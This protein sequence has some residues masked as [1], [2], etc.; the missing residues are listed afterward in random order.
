MVFPARSAK[1]QLNS[2]RGTM[3]SVRS[4]RRSYKQDKWSNELAVGK[5]PAGKN[6]STE[7]EDIVGIRHQAATGEDTV[8]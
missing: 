6:V 7:A 8:E 4:M 3:F 1:Q 2:N 5:S